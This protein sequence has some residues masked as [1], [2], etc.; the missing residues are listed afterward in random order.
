M[1]LKYFRAKPSLYNQR[2]QTPREISMLGKD[3]FNLYIK[4]TFANFKKMSDG[5]TL[6]RVNH[7][8]G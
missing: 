7:L 6:L 8:G 5:E 3:V 1:V 4:A 2:L